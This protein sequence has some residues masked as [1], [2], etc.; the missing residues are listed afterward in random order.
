MLGAP[1]MLTDTARFMADRLQ[2]KVAKAKLL[3]FGYTPKMGFLGRPGRIDIAKGIREDWRAGPFAA[4]PG[5]SDLVPT[6]DWSALFPLDIG[7]IA[8]L[9][10][11]P[12]PSKRPPF[13][14]SEAAS[15]AIVDKAMD[16]VPGSFPDFA[17]LTLAD[18]NL[19]ETER[20]LTETVRSLQTLADQ[21]VVYIPPAT[22]L[23]S[24]PGPAWACFSGELA[25]VV[26]RVAD[27][28]RAFAVTD[29]WRTHGVDWSDFLYTWTKSSEVL[30]DPIHTNYEGAQRAT[31]GLAH[32][33]LSDRLG[34][35]R[36]VEGENAQPALSRAQPNRAPDLAPPQ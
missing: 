34:L 16:A 20:D 29:D 5:L 13:T 32:L 7:N 3:L 6:P 25:R 33:V 9:L 27:R 23:Y 4:F 8:G 2:G 24:V 17:N 36:E 10:E 31:V 21:V 35:R 18:C 15:P 12:V 28:T 19:T 22:P 26:Q 14:P 1:D 11:R 30:V